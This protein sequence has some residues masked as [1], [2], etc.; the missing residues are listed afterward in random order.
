[1]IPRAFVP[2]HLWPMNRGNLQRAPMPKLPSM[3]AAAVLKRE[4]I[5]ETQKAERLERSKELAPAPVVKVR[6]AKRR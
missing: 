3:S 1:M 5:T 4:A 2:A 6:M